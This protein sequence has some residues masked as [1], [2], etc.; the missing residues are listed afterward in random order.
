MEYLVRSAE[1]LDASVNEA[2]RMGE[3]QTLL[4]SELYDATSAFADRW[5]DLQRDGERARR[6]G[7]ERM[8]QISVDL[9]EQM[10]EVTLNLTPTSS[11]SDHK[12][13]STLTYP[14]IKP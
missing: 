4:R 13:C 12:P 6:E 7:L 10:A 5:A 3:A 9:H 1:D 11:H 8:L 2:K 14:Y